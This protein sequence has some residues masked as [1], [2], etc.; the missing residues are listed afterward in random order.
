MRVLSLVLAL[1]VIG[2]VMLQ[3]AGGGDAETVIPESYQ[4]SLLKA[5]GVEEMLQKKA[6]QAMQKAEQQ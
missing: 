1:G 2:W 5:E 4:K 3:T 6:A